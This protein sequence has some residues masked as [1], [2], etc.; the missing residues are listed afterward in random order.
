MKSSI[1]SFEERGGSRVLLK[2]PARTFWG[3]Y[4]AIVLTTALSLIYLN[5]P[6]YAFVLNKALL[7]KYF[8]FGLVPILSP[9]LLLKPRAFLSYLIS[10]FPLWIFVVIILNIIHLLNAFVEGNTG[11]VDLVSTRIQLLVVAIGLG[12]A[13]AVTRTETYERVFPFLTVLISCSVIFDFF[14]P[15][16][17]YPIG[18]EGSVINRGAATFINPTIAAE[19]MLIVFLMTCAAVK[20]QY[21]MPLLILTG[22]GVT[23]TFTRSA[24]IAWILF[25]IFLSIKRVFSRLAALFTLAAF[26]VIPVLYDTFGNYLSS[27][28]NSGES[29]ANI[30]ARLD[31]FS[32]P[33]FEDGSSEERLKVLKAGWNLFLQNP[34][35]GAGAGA[36]HFWSYKAGTHNQLVMLGAEYGIL[37]IVLWA[38]LAIILWRGK[39]F[40]NKNLQFAVFCLFIFMS[41]FTHNMF[42]SPYWLVTFALIAGTRKA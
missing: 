9:V 21:R 2:R 10:P 14:I 3:R 18:M 16:V 34:V 35:S 36:T 12:F 38:S 29:I 28:E 20:M 39:H 31:F 37:G 30:Q 23:V 19:V 40:Q 5:L 6:G 15:G 11:T 41:M 27:R 4:N 42:D 13:L 26:I 25:W 7:P 8:Y 32:N 22:V 24:I 1:Q 17:L 33:N